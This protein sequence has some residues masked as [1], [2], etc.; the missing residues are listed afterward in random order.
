MPDPNQKWSKAALSTVAEAED[1]SF[2]KSRRTTLHS[3]DQTSGEGNVRQKRY[4]NSYRRT[5]EAIS[6]AAKADE[7]RLP[8]G[9]DKQKVWPVAKTRT[10]LIDPQ[11]YLGF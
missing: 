8:P 11:K 5:L 2:V 7:L 6:S 1:T 3:R 9:E 10:I 4:G